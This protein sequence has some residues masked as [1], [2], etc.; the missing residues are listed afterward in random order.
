[1][2]G[3]REQPSRLWEPEGCKRPPW[4]V[5]SSQLVLR[6]KV[7]RSRPEQVGRSHTA[8]PGVGTLLSMQWEASGGF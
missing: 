8:G 6:D 5:V 4:G 2:M 3:L 7:V 1:M